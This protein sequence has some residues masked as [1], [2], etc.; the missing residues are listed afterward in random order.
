M[1]L[2]RSEKRRKNLAINLITA[3]IM[4]NRVKLKKLYKNNYLS[5]I[6]SVNY[7]LGRTTPRNKY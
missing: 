2:S 4:P 3:K 6:I 1:A 7:R 5:C